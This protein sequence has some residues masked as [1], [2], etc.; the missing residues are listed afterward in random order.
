[1]MNV[2]CI[3]EKLLIRFAGKWIVRNSS[4]QITEQ[5]GTEKG[6]S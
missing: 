3:Q 1:V 4:C 2:E 5:K 6:S